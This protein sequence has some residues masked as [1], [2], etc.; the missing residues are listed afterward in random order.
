MQICANER[1]VFILNLAKLTAA[2]STKKAI[3]VKRGELRKVPV[4]LFFSYYM[5]EVSHYKVAKLVN[6]FYMKQADISTL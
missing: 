4:A 3:C 1:T 2:L 6:P 5:N